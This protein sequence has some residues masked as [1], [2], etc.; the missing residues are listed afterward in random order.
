MRFVSTAEPRSIALL[1]MLALLGC[2]DS[3]DPLR[4]DARLRSDGG[5]ADGGPPA[6]ATL[7]F[8][9]RLVIDADNAGI[10]GAL[11]AHG[12]ELG[13]AYFRKV[14]VEN[15]PTVSCP[16]SALGSG[17]VDRQRP[18]Q[19]VMYA[20]FDGT[21]WQPAVKVDQTIGPTH[22][23]SLVF[24]HQGRPN[25]GYLGGAPSQ[26]GC[27]SSDAVASQSADQGATWSK[28]TFSAAGST[29]DTVG[30]WTTLAVD[31]AGEV[32]ATYRDVHFGYYEQDGNARAEW[33]YDGGEDVGGLDLNSQG[34]GDGMYATMLFTPAPDC[35]AVALAANL[36][37]QSP[38]RHGLRIAV[39]ESSGWTEPRLLVAGGIE[40]R[41]SLASDGRGRY[42]IAY[43][44][45]RDK[46]LRYIESSDLEGWSSPELVDL[47]TT[48]HGLYSSLAFD[49]AG[50]PAISYYRCS[51]AGA[52]QCEPDNDAVMLAYRLGGEWRTWVVDD[53]GEQLCGR[54]TSLAFAPNNEPMVAYECV[55]LRNEGNAFLS[56]AKVAHGVWK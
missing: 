12:T 29:G 55:G 42:A 38:A 36:V 24:D 49:A 21:S 34:Y 13:L 16:P 44:D 26:R 54:Y 43:F 41:P 56:G 7:S 4:R 25:V 15:E 50:N 45:S 17:F 52:T 37:A 18:A 20:R 33:R 47:S 48:Q 39:R 46:S 5:T 27:D 3:G 31:C 32:H 14:P 53:G 11:A 30:H 10:Q 28:R 51:R 1:V 23:L 35:R 2:S 6:G 8:V 40:E 9:S 19:D 22:G